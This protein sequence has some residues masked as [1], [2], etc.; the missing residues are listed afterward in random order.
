MFL[1]RKMGFAN[2]VGGVTIKLKSHK[3]SP[4][5]SS[6]CCAL[7]AFSKA[8]M[9]ELVYAVDLGSTGGFPPSGFDP[10]CQQ[11]IHRMAKR[12]GHTAARLEPDSEKFGFQS[13]C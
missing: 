11:F 10:R 6:Y 8:G 7:K 9:A 3:K 4:E 1:F 5:G 13:R 12:S 2:I